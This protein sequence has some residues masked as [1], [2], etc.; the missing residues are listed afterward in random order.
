MHGLSEQDILTIWEVGQRQHPVEQAMTILMLADASHSRNDMLAMS[1]GQRDAHLLTIYESS[2]GTRFA[3][4]AECLQC[5]GPLEFSFDAGDI[6][7]AEQD[8][9]GRTF[10]FSYEGYEVQAKLPDSTDMFAIAGCRDVLTARSILLERC[11]AL[12]THQG[13]EIEVSALPDSM[14]A[15]LG[16][17]MIERDP[18]AEIR[19]ELACPSCDHRWYALFDILVFLW[20]EII[21]RAR[22]TLYDVH[23]LA[24]AYGWSESDILAMSAVRR[25]LYLDMVTV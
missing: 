21:A 25:R 22:R 9:D 13:S 19:L 23:L 24:S 8:S 18:Q 2:F 17:A 7:T 4:Y 1:I 12:T 5:R 3:G 15:A 14:I 10:N 20:H 16:E 11:I 6:R